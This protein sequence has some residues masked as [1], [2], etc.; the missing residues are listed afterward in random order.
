MLIEMIKV[1]V[2]YFIDLF[3]GSLP[4]LYYQ[5]MVLLLAVHIVQVTVSYRLS[6]PAKSYTEH[7][8]ENMAAFAVLILSGILLSR[9]FTFIV[10]DAFITTSG[11]QDYFISLIITTAFV[12]TGGFRELL[13]KKIQ[14]KNHQFP[15]M[16]GLAVIMNILCFMGLLPLTDGLFQVTRAFM[17]TLITAVSVI[18]LVLFHFDRPEENPVLT[19]D[20]ASD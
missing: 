6:R 1:A 4:A 3:S 8:A 17:V 7:F 16:L 9:F 14:N 5:W 15:V 11:F 12:L 19:G 18:M 20:G 13:Q 2:N 10:D